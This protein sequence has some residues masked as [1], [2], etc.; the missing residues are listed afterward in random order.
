MPETHARFLAQGRLRQ[1]SLPVAATIAAEEAAR[2][3]GLSNVK[4][5]TTDLAALDLE[6]ESFDAAICRFGLMF[7]ASPQAGLSRVRHA[8]K[9]DARLAALVWSTEAKNP[10]M[11]TVVGVLREMGRLPEPPPTILRAVSLSSPEVL[12]RAFTGAGFRDVSVRAVPVVREFSS[13]AETVEMLRTG[14]PQA[15]LLRELSEAEREP[16]WSEVARRL[17]AFERPDGRVTVPG[18]ALLAVATK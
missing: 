13:L 4:T 16:V 8:L 7:L 1:I 11:S 3:A 14:A 18:E 10:Y 15:E 17:R 12:E 5:L 9:T 6:A 2:A